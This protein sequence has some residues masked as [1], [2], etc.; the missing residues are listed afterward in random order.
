MRERLRLA[1]RGAVQGVGFR[2]SAYRLARALDLSGWVLN[3]PA[4]VVIEIEGPR[5]QLEQFRARLESEPPPHATIVSVEATWLERVGFRGFEIRD[6][7]ECGEPTA[8]VMPDLATCDACRRELFDPDD[9]RYRYPFINCTH[10]GPRYSIIESLPYDR[11]RTSMR[12]FAMCPACAK[13]YHDPADRRFHAQPNACPVCGPQLEWWS[14]SGAVLAERDE[15]LGA[16]VDA[17]RR[18]CIVAVKGL[19]GFHLMVDARQE[20]SVRRLRQ[21]KHREEKPFALMYPSLAD[22][23]RDCEVGPAEARLLASAEAPIVLLRR[24]ADGK[25]EIAAS[26]APGAP[27]LG[28][29][30]P[31]TPI[32]HLIAAD[33]G[34]ALVATSG[35]FSDEPICTDERDAV[36]R[37]SRIADAFLVHDRPILR[38]VDDSIVRVMAGREMVLRRARGYAP[39]PVRLSEDAP[40]LVAVGAHLKSTVAVTS[41][42]NVFISQ[43]LGDLETPQAIEAFE[44]VMRDVKGLFH[45]APETVVA[46]LHPDYFSSRYARGLGLPVATVQHHLAHVTACLA[47]NDIAGPALGV[48]W[49]GTGYGAD[50]T[51]WGGEFL[52]ITDHAWHRAACLRPFPLPGGEQ[53]IREPRRSALGLLYAMAGPAAID[54]DAAPLRAFDVSD[55]RLLMQALERHVNAPIT[56]SAGRLF[57]AVASI[58]DLRQLAGFEG[59]AAMMLEWAADETVVD[60]YPFEIT[61]GVFLEDSVL[62]KDTRRYFPTL[63]LD[64]EPMIRALLADVARGAPTAT[65]ASRFHETLARMI[66]AVAEGVGWPRVA[67]SGGCFQNRLL[68]ERTIARLRAAGFSPCWHQRVPTNDGGIALGQIAAFVRGLDTPPQPAS[69]D[70]ASRRDIA[71][72]LAGGV[73]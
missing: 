69:L 5:E 68:L 12:G 55:R 9:R 50:G 15:A 46:D 28:V 70:A 32:H 43:H 36:V 33:F 65:M 44:R 35:N 31:Y 48:S 7:E 61:P 58:L 54:L 62:Q 34:A 27:T 63:V 30:L 1:V 11:A 57:D 24:R 41:G 29:M 14:N 47:E 49:D 59:Q 17:L 3:G 64:W 52:A 21:R 66:V 4:G 22:V 16:A 45:A 37:L 72:A 60:A 26:V 18:G 67:L 25:S 8:L 20:C 51:I 10:C 40:R 73:S 6:S 56:T 71:P 53:A 23:R 39:M 2:P 19:G 38:H 13:E 42:S